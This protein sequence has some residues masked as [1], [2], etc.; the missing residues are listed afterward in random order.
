MNSINS[1]KFLA[2]YY[3]F[4]H[5]L[6]YYRLSKLFRSSATQLNSLTKDVPDS[7]YTVKRGWKGEY[8]QPRSPTRS[9]V[10]IWSLLAEFEISATSPH[11]RVWNR[12]LKRDALRQS[13]WMVESKTGPE[14]PDK[15][16]LTTR[17]A[18]RPPRGGGVS[19]GSSSWLSGL[20]PSITDMT[21]SLSGSSSS[22]FRLVTSSS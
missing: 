21:V 10:E 20:S 22:S 16:Y 2:L 19:S 9:V 1:H 7:G 14:G 18:G 3:N 13:R 15:H 5:P 8:N 17:S 6:M 4:S 12:E 11:R